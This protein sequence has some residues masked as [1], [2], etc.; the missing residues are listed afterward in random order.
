MN[1]DDVVKK[2][3]T[4]EVAAVLL[5]SA[6]SVSAVLSISTPVGHATQLVTLGEGRIRNTIDGGLGDRGG[7]PAIALGQGCDEVD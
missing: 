4:S 1:G 6:A 7:A 2:A 3:H 5:S